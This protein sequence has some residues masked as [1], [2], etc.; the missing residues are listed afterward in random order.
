MTKKYSPMKYSYNVLL[1]I[2]TI[3]TSACSTLPVDYADNPSYAFTDTA[4]TTLAEKAK[5]ISA[6]N[7]DESTMYLVAEGTEAFLTRMALLKLA[8]RSVNLQY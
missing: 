7:P 3:V 2:V 8:E 4:Q 1:I 5:Q 6:G